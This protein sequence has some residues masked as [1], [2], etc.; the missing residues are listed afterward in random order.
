VVRMGSTL[1]M[2]EHEI[3]IQSLDPAFLFDGNYANLPDAVK[4]RLLDYLKTGNYPGKFLEGVL[5]NDLR[6]TI[7]YG[8]GTEYE[9]WYAFLPLLV[10]WAYNNCPGN[11]VGRDNYMRHVK[12]RVGSV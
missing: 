3:G 1:D 5:I 9:P 6:Q 12:N 10:K 7:N 11:L 4:A 8:Q 2:F